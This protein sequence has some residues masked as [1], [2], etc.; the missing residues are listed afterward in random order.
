MKQNPQTYPVL[1]IPFFEYLR[2]TSW[3]RMASCK[4]IIGLGNS[5]PIAGRIVV[6]SFS[7][8]KQQPADNLTKLLQSSSWELVTD[9]S[10]KSLLWM[11]DG[12]MMLPHGLPDLVD[13]L[14]EL[15]QN[16]FNQCTVMILD[17]HFNMACF[18]MVSAPIRIMH[19]LITKIILPTMDTS[20]KEHWLGEFTQCVESGQ[21]GNEETGYDSSLLPRPYR[22]SL[23]PHETFFREMEA[24]LSEMESYN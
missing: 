8:V 18:F 12:M 14:H 10:D 5:V 17:G 1:A 23:V 9:S 19:P 15:V 24:P 22:L 4:P 16:T 13:Q 20:A 21:A 7:L 3:I 2:L 6:E 11:S